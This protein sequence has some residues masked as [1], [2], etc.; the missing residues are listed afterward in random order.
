VSA[1]ES[2]KISRFLMATVLLVLAGV[3]GM[4]LRDR[5][6]PLS[7]PQ[8]LRQHYDLLLARLAKL[9]DL[10]AANTIPD[11]AYRA[12]RDDLMGRLAAL[13]MLLRSHGGVHA[14]DRGAKAA[15][16]KVQ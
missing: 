1:G 14:P 3:V 15:A 6:D 10:H 5:H 4:S 13:A 16:A 11:D 9:D 7:D 8:V 2:E 12:S